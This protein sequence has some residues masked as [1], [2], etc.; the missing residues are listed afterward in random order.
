MGKFFE[1]IK[2]SLMGVNDYDEEEYE[3][4]LEEDAVML[5]PIT[6]SAKSSR[7]GTL[8]LDRSERPRGTAQTEWKIH[9]ETGSRVTEGVQ[10]RMKIVKAMP[11]TIADSRGIIDDVKKEIVTFVDLTDLEPLIKQRIAD[12]LSGGVYALEGTVSRVND[13][14]FF[15][16]PSSVD[17][18]EYQEELQQKNKTLF[19]GFGFNNLP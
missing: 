16:A 1:T 15:V 17:I 11:E 5:T 2:N 7:P 3:D 4:R 14:S 8:T 9:S 10:R 18:F 13:N 6:T 12:F 19:S